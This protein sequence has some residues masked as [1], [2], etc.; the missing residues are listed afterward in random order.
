M[1]INIEVNENQAYTIRNAL[2][3]YSRFLMGQFEEID[4]KMVEFS[5]YWKDFDKRD[6]IEELIKE[7]RDLI[8]PEL[9]GYAHW[10]ISNQNCPIDSKNA[11]DIIQVLRYELWKFKDDKDIYGTVDS[12]APLKFGDQE[13]C[14]VVVSDE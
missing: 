10:G 8:Y 9:K 13:L 5:D 2:D 11:Y 1:K 12:H 14:K 7:L 3:F 6:K 4:R